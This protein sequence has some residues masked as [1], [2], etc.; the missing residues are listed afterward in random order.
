ML[1]ETRNAN[2]LSQHACV[3]FALVALSVRTG[4]LPKL[5]IHGAAYALRQPP[6]H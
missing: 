4:R 2:L 6:Q 1:Y 5:L 3:A